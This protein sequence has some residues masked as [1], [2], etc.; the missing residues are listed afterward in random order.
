MF[1]TLRRVLARFFSTSCAPKSRPGRARQPALELLET[2]DVPTVTYQGGYL[3]PHVQVQALYLGSDWAT[4][5]SQRQMVRNFDAFLQTIVNSPYM[6]MLTQ[7]GYM[8][9]RGS[10]IPGRIDRSVLNKH[11]AITDAMIQQT[12]RT[13]IS[14]HLLA[15]LSSN[16]LYVVFVERGVVVNANANVDVGGSSVDGFVGYHDV[17]AYRGRSVPYAVIPY[18]APPNGSDTNFSAFGS[19]TE[20][21]SH[22]LAESI[23]DPGIRGTTGWYDDANNGEIA[24]LTDA[25]SIL[26]GYVVQN[27]VDQ[28]DNVLSPSNAQG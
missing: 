17:F 16:R 26:D 28:N 11:L 8:V 22:E 7:A 13:D 27:V 20:S 25:I 1:S 4:V 9:G 3:L 5:P 14:D 23:T 18:Q 19:A 6:D 12:L 15:G 10:A 2:R 24:D 21:L